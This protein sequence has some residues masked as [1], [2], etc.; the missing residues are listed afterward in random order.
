MD[1][2]TSIS[3]N[4]LPKACV[5]AESL[6]K[7][8]PDWI[9]HLLISD[10]LPLDGAESIKTQL[11]HPRFDKVIWIDQLDIP[12]LSSWIFKHTVVEL[13][14]AVK[15]PY[16]QQLVK[17]GSTSIIYIDPDIAVF[18]E[19]SPLQSL[20]DHS[21]ILLTPHLLDYSDEPQAIVDNEI[22]GTM[23]HG[24][25]NLGFFAVNA[26]REDGKRF[27][28]WWGNRLLNY[29][30]ADYERGLF[31]DQKWCDMVPAFFQDH[32]IVRDP[33]YNVASWNINHRQLSISE[34]GQILVNDIYPLRFYHFTGY[35]SGAGN[36]MTHRYCA[37]IELVEEIW[38]WYARTL[39][40]MA[41]DE[42]GSRSCYY[43]F[44]HDGSLISKEDRKVYRERIDLQTAYP[45][46][47]AI[48]HAV[49]RSF[50]EK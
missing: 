29:C 37:Q 5:L 14:T 19:L 18:N 16:L 42:L 48:S 44:Y 28:D 39:S 13:C 35:D 15:G 30:Y 23:R 27:T 12:H 38:T 26:A 25:F 46:P 50:V 11:N 22:A 47:F 24:I 41:Q 49:I 10:K 34:S 36:F 45:D 21:A 4:Y 32:C 43:N 33:G 40:R 31:T 6:K 2:F 7:Y 20:L 3:L 8:H 17:E 9:F 1:V